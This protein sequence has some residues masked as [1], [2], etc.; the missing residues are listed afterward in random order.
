MDSIEGQFDAL[1]ERQK[2]ELIVDLV[3][4]LQACV[5]QLEEWS[6][7]FYTKEDREGLEAARY[8]LNTVLQ[9]LASR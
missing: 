9:R 7:E 1:L 4:E 8:V 6:P 2:N 5:G 3:E